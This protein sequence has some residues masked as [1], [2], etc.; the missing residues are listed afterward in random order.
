MVCHDTHDGCL[1][2]PRHVYEHDGAMMLAWHG[3]AQM[4][5]LDCSD[6][7]KQMEKQG[8]MILATPSCNKKQFTNIEKT[9]NI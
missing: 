9:N 7:D 5:V 3:R 2:S 1:I 6:D 8:R 4:G